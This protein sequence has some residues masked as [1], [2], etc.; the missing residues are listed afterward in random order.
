[1][2]IE[3]IRDI[4]RFLR[5]YGAYDH[6]SLD[7]RSLYF[8]DTQF[9][10]FSRLLGENLVE[11][12]E[13]ASSVIFGKGSQNTQYKKL[14]SSFSASALNT[15]TFLD[16]DKPDI[17][18]LTRATYKA[19]KH[20]FYVTILLRLGSRRGAISLAKKTFRLS[21]KYELHHVSI[22][23]LDQLRI[24]EL[25]EGNKTQFEKYVK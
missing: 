13:E 21:E 2:K 20:L 14:K 23:L 17:S 10:K 5:Q 9:G 24:N 18:G 3:E 12:D 1:M 4:L 7:L 6:P 16:L 25:L 22:E 8:A 19:Y 15:I 11:K